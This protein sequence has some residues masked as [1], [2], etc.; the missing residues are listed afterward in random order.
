[1]MKQWHILTATALSLWLAYYSRNTWDWSWIIYENLNSFWKLMSALPLIS[2]PYIIICSTLPDWDGNWKITQTW[3][4]KPIFWLI[5]SLT[6]HRGFT[7]RIEGI[8]SFFW[9]LYLASLFKPNLLILW[10]FLYCSIA[11]LNILIEN[12][13]FR[14]I[15]IGIILIFS[16]ILLIPKYY[17]AFLVSCGIGYLFH[18]AADAISN[19]GWTIMKFWKRRLR[20][21]LWRYSFR[22]W[23][24]FEKKF[25]YPVLLFAIGFVLFQDWQFFLSKFI[26]E[27][28][29]TLEIY[30]DFIQ[31]PQYYIN[32]VQ[33]QL[34]DLQATFVDFKGYIESFSGSV[35]K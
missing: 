12:N 24:S 21:K 30:K 14:K 1:M 25:I 31:N 29:V 32:P 26:Y 28:W 35:N 34:T 2:I 15:M 17:L 23:S 9:L 10:I 33:T 19:E 6:A 3:F 27:W 4:L 16:P 11:M 20:I 5:Q 22:V 13:I 7:H 8:L 18:F